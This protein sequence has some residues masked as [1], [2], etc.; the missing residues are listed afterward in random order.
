V[1]LL[2]IGATRCAPLRTKSITLDR[3]QSQRRNTTAAAMGRRAATPQVQMSI[4][5][6][7]AGPSAA[8]V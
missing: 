5:R 1:R 4:D 8:Q 3:A 2:L 6:L 7:R